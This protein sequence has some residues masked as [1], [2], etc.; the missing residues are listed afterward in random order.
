MI[1][2][3]KNSTT[4]VEAISAEVK[5]I[6]GDLE[7]FRTTLDELAQSLFMSQLE[8][9]GAMDT[10]DTEAIE[11]PRERFKRGGL[12]VR[13]IG[14]KNE[15]SSYSPPRDW[16]QRTGISYSSTK[17]KVTRKPPKNY[18]GLYPNGL[19]KSDQT[20]GNILHLYATNNKGNIFIN[21][22]DRY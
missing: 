5:A 20:S 8:I 3:D 21:I 9:Q 4:E 2:K 18:T 6:L 14:T 17:T 11:V 22:T 13:V 15:T 1:F 16:E 19:I 7:K 12:R 10:L